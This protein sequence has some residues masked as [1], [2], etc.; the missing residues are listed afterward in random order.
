MGCRKEEVNRGQ[1]KFSYQRCHNTITTEQKAAHIPSS[2]VAYKLFC[3]IQKVYAFLILDPCASHA[4]RKY[5]PYARDV[6]GQAMTMANIMATCSVFG[7]RLVTVFQS[8]ISLAF[9][10]NMD[11]RVIAFGWSIGPC[12]SEE[13]QVLWGEY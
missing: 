5:R 9:D 11:M 7:S 3:F 8:M 4:V 1:I 10:D 6:T 2:V 13:P 12:C